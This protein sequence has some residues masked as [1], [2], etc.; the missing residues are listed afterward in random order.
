MI[1]NLFRHRLFT[2]AALICLFY[3]LIALILIITSSTQVLGINA[4]I[5]PFKF[6]ISAFILFLTFSWYFNFLPR[7]LHKPFHLFAWVN[8]AVMAF[9]LS[10]ILIQAYRGTLSHF[11]MSTAFEGIMFGIMGIS[12]A[13]S[14]TWTLLLFKWT[15]AKDFRMNPGLLQA[16]RFGIVLFVIFGFTGFIM[17]ANRSH[18]VGA[19]DGGPG[20]FLLNWSLTYGDIRISHFFGLHA[21]QI[22]PL[23]ASLFK[24]RARSSFVMSVLY[25]IACAS[26]LY[27]ALSGKP[28]Y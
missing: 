8:I 1:A 24:L 2:R 11:N 6:G 7:R 25:G 14:T 10:W 28:P 19:P 13:I 27:L 15:F 4:F 22:L 16:V 5:K 9:E 18:T 23:K 26:L 17:G 21:L 12:I 20:I 3:A